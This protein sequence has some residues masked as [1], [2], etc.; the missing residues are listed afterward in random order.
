VVLVEQVVELLVA[1]VVVQVRQMVLRFRVR[2]QSFSL[3]QLAPAHGRPANVVNNDNNYYRGNLK[4][5]DKTFG[6]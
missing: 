2:W 4:W 6:Q 5:M 3:V 1:L